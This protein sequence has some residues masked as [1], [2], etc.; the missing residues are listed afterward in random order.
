ME[1]VAIP[2][3]RN[4]GLDRKEKSCPSVGRGKPSRRPKSRRALLF[5]EWSKRQV[6]MVENSLRDVLPMS[7][8]MKDELSDL[9][10]SLTTKEGGN[11]WSKGQFWYRSL[12]SSL[13]IAYNP[14]NYFND[15]SSLWWVPVAMASLAR[16]TLSMWLRL[17][18]PPLCC[19]SPRAWLPLG[20][21]NAAP[22]ADR[23][24]SSIP[25]CA[26]ARAGPSRTR[27]RKN[28]CGERLKRCTHLQTRSR[29]SRCSRAETW[30]HLSTVFS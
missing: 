24:L 16:S 21:A 19:Y 11:N 13:R 17:P 3:S 27:H 28:H 2:S 8:D 29:S 4:I 10:A 26:L 22:R 14:H 1:R 30:N 15:L 5:T 25:H 6:L 12:I 18:N 7:K 9:Y 20:S 23:V